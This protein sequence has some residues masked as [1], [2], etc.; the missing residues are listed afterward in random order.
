MLSK[1]M[2]TDELFEIC[3]E[4]ASLI[5]TQRWEITSVQMS[6]EQ[7]PAGCS[8]VIFF[9]IGILCLCQYKTQIF[10]SCPLIMKNAIRFREL[11]CNIIKTK[12]NVH[13]RTKV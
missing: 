5:P 7:L 1:P 3:K 2:L 9:K 13:S 10:C 12:Y 6:N 8:H 4:P 11:Q